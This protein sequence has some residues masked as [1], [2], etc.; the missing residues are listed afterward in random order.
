MLEVMKFLDTHGIQSETSNLYEPWQNGTAEHMI[1]TVVA[2]ARTVMLPSGLEGRFW[3]HAIQYAVH[4]HNIQFSKTTQSSPFYLMHG[5]KPD[6]SS[7][8]QFGVEGW[9]H[10][11]EDQRKDAKFDAWGEP[12][13]FV[14]Y[15]TNQQ[16]FLVWCPNRGPNA[17]ISTTNVVFGIRCPR[18]KRPEVEILHDHTTELLLPQK[19][20]ILTVQEVKKAC[21]LKIVGTFEGNFVVTDSN[22]EGVRSLRPHEVL[23]VLMF[24]HKHNFA[25][26]HLFLVDSYNFH[27]AHFPSDV[28]VSE[29]VK[30]VPRNVKEALSPKFVNE[31][32]PAIDK[33]NQGFIKHNCFKAMPLPEGAKTLPGQWIFS[34]KRRDNTPKARFVI[35]GHRQILGK[36]YFV[37]KNYCSVL[38]SRD[39]SVLLALAAVEKW[40]VYQLRLTLCKPFCTGCW[41]LYS[42]TH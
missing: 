21:D 29:E 22:F 39:N 8:Q 24:T 32:G 15:P 5:E 12:C 41:Y 28:F 11:K 36:D 9:I 10:S 30:N 27:A 17:I 23:K 1:Q 37:N 33:E 42:T 16:G 18:S 4:F 38:S 2:T 26:A 7:D 19:P 20:T 35:G 13:L 31:F 34:R 25:S 3:Y 6:V 40:Q 14:G